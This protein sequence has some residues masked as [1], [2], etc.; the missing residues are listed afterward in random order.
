M[1]TWMGMLL[2]ALV[3]AGVAVVGINSLKLGDGAADG[4]PGE[5]GGAAAPVSYT[6]LRAHET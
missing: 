1:K 3:G 5:A 2:A 4:T 6:H